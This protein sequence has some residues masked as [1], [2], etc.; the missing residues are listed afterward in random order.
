MCAFTRFSSRRRFGSLRL[1]RGPNVFQ[2]QRWNPEIV[3]GVGCSPRLRRIGLAAAAGLPIRTELAAPIALR[4][5]R[6]GRR[7]HPAH[8][9]VG[10][11]VVLRD[12]LPE[13]AVI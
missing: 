4:P 8:D 13:L 5:S 12:R 2:A 10:V 6:G 7:V 3:E 9:L 11:L 1:T